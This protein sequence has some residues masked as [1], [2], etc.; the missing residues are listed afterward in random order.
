MRLM[1]SINIPNG[2]KKEQYILPNN[3]AQMV[4][5][6]KA[7]PAAMLPSASILERDGA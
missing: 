6:M 2:Q 4:N 5:V 1:M 7:E 3:N